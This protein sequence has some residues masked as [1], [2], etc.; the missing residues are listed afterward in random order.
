MVDPKRFIK[1]YF[2]GL[3]MVHSGLASGQAIFA[4]IAFYL[5]NQGKIEP[6]PVADLRNT[7]IFLIPVLVISGIL[8]GNLFFRNRVEKA[9]GQP[10]LT[11]KLI[12]Y[13]VGLMGRYAILETTSLLSSVACLL[14]GDLFFLVFAGFV[15]LMFLFIRVSGEK[16]ATDLELNSQ[17]KSLF[18]L[19]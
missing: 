12:M 15:I 14:T 9:K 10:D 16:V 2:L 13:R 5:V 11:F 3:K 4:L 8:V 7:L 1:G 19:E 6:G 17:E 18:D